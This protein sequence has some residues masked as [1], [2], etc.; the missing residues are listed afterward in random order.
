MLFFRRLQN[1]LM[2]ANFKAELAMYDKIDELAKY[3]CELVEKVEAALV[4]TDKTIALN[5]QTRLVND[6]L[7]RIKSDDESGH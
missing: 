5:Q 7:Q 3:E 2:I 1:A 4:M 6:I